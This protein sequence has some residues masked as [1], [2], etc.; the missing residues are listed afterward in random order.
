MPRKHKPGVRVE[1]T[2]YKGIVFRRYPDSKR[3]TDRL[4]FKPGKEWA[5]GVDYLHR[6]VWKDHYGDIPPNH[7]IHHKDGDCGNNSIENL[8]CLLVS[9][10]MQEHYS[11]LTEG[12]K[13]AKKDNFRRAAEFAKAWHG[14]EE[15]H[16]WH[17][18]HGKRCWDDK[19]PEM[20]ICEHC[21][22]EYESR[23]THDNAKFCSNACKSAHRRSIGADNEQRICPACGKPFMVN[24]YTDTKCCSRFCAQRLRRQENR[25]A[26]F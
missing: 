11:R 5:E 18:E 8:E 23:V 7:H 1:K 9:D 3:R 24:K 21:G 13:Q 17:V 6:E 15:G 16:E 14:S 25:A 12:Q 4:Y 26:G 22:K 20:H 10:H 19:L 2:V